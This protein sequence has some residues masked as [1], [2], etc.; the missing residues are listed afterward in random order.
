[1]DYRFIVARNDEQEL[2]GQ[3][4]ETARDAYDHLRQRA[5]SEQM[6]IQEYVVK[7]IEI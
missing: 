2:T 3:V 5:E 7:P 6:S 1:M 4:F